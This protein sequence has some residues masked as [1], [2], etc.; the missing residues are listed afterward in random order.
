M[1]LIAAALCAI[2]IISGIGAYA[3]FFAFAKV[4]NGH[5]GTGNL[6][7]KINGNG[8]TTVMPIA[9]DAMIPGYINGLP[10][11]DNPQFN[12][13]A[14]GGYEICYNTTTQK[15]ADLSVYL[16]NISDDCGGMLINNLSA[17]VFYSMDGGRWDNNVGQ[18]GFKP[19]GTTGYTRYTSG[20]HTAM[21]L[22][23]F[24][25]LSQWA[26]M[27]A[28]INGD[29]SDPLISDIAPNTYCYRWYI[30]FYL[31]ELDPTGTT[32]ADNLLQGKT[33]TFDLNFNAVPRNN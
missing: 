7:I 12:D 2:L 6:Q 28:P 1:T 11:G 15:H 17:F 32:G 27:T 19:V 8:G 9:L 26:A 13:I 30:A 4:Q 14:S 5:A 31:P 20:I 18:V 29:K 23:D 16:T 3:Y 22:S 25:P 33:A 24:T 10:N 21:T